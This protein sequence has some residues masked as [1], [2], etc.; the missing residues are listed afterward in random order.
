MD[1]G[2]A[3]DSCIIHWDSVGIL[4]TNWIPDLIRDKIKV[5]QGW[6]VATVDFRQ[7]SCSNSIVNDQKNHNSILTPRNQDSKNS[8]CPAE[9]LKNTLNRASE[10]KTKDDVNKQLIELY[11]S[12]KFKKIQKMILET[13]EYA[14]MVT[15]ENAILRAKVESGKPSNWNGASVLDLNFSSLTE[16]QLDTWVS[17]VKSVN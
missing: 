8:S 2:L 13:Q 7:L 9:N 1:R 6:K 12:E 17:K 5:Y 3:A 15:R 16:E 10:A 11:K 14:E 4:M